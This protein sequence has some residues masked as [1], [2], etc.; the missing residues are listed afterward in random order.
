MTRRILPSCAILICLVGCNDNA[1][2]DP[3][4]LPDTTT[5]TIQGSDTVSQPTVVPMTDTVATTATTDTI[6]GHG[7]YA[8]DSV[9]APDSDKLPSRPPPP[10]KLEDSV[11]GGWD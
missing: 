6:L 7:T 5:V 2:D 10:P 3:R 1:G 11:R 8:P 9:D 4:V